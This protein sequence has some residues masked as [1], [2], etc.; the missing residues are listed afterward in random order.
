MRP[1]V[2]TK[3]GGHVG[4]AVMLPGGGGVG[5]VRFAGPPNQ[6]LKQNIL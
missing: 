5:G 6:N 4:G 3:G 2:R 1:S